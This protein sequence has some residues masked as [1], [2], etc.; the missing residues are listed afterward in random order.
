MLLFL[1]NIGIY[2]YRTL[3]FI[4]SL[5]QPKIKLFVAGRNTIA[6]L[7]Q[8]VSIPKHKKKIWI[9]CASLGEFEQGRPIIESLR[10][11]YPDAYIVVT[12]F[13]PSGYE[14]RKH[15]TEV[16]LVMYMDYDT[17]EK[18]T[19]FVQWL[20]PELAIFVKYEF[21]FH[22]LSALHQ[23]GT[24][25]IFIGTIFQERHIFFKW[26]GQL[27]RKMLK[28]IDFL[29]VQDQH[30][31]DLLKQINITNCAIAGDPRF[32][33]AKITASLPFNDTVINQFIHK[34]VLVAGST[35]TDDLVLLKSWFDL[36]H[37]HYQLIIAP[38]NINETTVSEIETL[39]S[40]YRLQRYT[41]YGANNAT[42][43][44]ILNTFGVLSKLYRK[45]NIVWIGGGWNK[46]GIHNSVEAAVYAKPLF[47]G[48]IYSRYREATDL[49]AV[50][51]AKSLNTS[52]A[53]H[54]YTKNEKALSQMSD[55]AFLYVS[56][57]VGATNIIMDYIR[58]KCFSNKP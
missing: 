4:L 55:N 22:H 32:D 53:L 23:N 45:A 47:W 50:N 10:I 1:Y 35:W 6:Q 58:L 20:Q 24:Q 3:A 12:F 29:F 44:L 27:H 48:P 33:Q 15:Y 25:I 14:V 40:A 54:E 19:L 13:S 37:Q 39:F 51:G 36:N 28:Y 18:A 43:V 49:V 2:L 30:S 21:W 42:D 46:T 5:F 8:S 11:T 41:S 34:P 26:Y 38:H 31:I 52:I 16:D 17:K 57:Q 56:T 9:H 7:Y